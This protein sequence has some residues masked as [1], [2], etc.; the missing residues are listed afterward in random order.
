[1]RQVYRKL[2]SNLADSQVFRKKDKTKWHCTNCGYV[3]EGNE[4]PKICPACQH[5][6]SYYEVLAE[7]Y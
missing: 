6:Q 7:N 1:M 4:A 2:I 3:Y 5:P